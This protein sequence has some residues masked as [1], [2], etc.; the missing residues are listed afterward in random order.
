MLVVT[1]RVVFRSPR[2]P[3]AAKTTADGKEVVDYAREALVLIATLDTC[4]NA[5][6]FRSVDFPALRQAR[7]K[8]CSEGLLLALLREYHR[9][10]KAARPGAI[11][12]AAAGS[13]ATDGRCGGD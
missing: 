12:N 11:D 2:T 10:M 9:S 1:G 3:G 4:S 5:A 7:A 8:A 6:D 13:G